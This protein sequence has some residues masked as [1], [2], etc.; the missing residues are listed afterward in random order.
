[1]KKSVRLLALTVALTVATVL[2]TSPVVVRAVEPDLFFL[3]E[4]SLLMQDAETPAPEGPE[5]EPETELPAT[6]EAE[7]ASNTGKS[8]EDAETPAPEPEPLSAE[9][10]SVDI[11]WTNTTLVYTAGSW[12][13][14]SLSY[15]TGSWSGAPSVRVTNNSTAAVNVSCSFQSEMSGVSGTFSSIGQLDSNQSGTATLTLNGTPK[16]WS[17]SVTVG[18]AS[19][20]ITTVS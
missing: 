15:G 18:T 8:S 16:P 5:D 7:P 11:A 20:S 19:V 14:G 4:T 17:G 12:D 10:Y 3:E 6:P 2:C 1:M 9:T 13:T